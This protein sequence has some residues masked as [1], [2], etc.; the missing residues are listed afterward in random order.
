MDKNKKYNKLFHIWLINLTGLVCLIIIVGGLTRLTDSGLSITAWELFSGILPPMSQESWIKYYD[1]YKKIPQYFLLNNSMTLEEFKVIFLWEYAHRLLARVIGLFFLI[2]F[3]FFI[4]TNFLKKEI[5]LKLTYVFILILIQGLMGW[6]MVQS[7]LIENITVSHYRLSIHLFIAF[8]IL[9]SLIWILL[10]SINKTNKFFFQLNTSHFILKFLLFLLFVQ[11]ILGAFVS[12]LDAGKIYQTWPLMNGNFF[13]DDIPINYFFNFNEP[14][15]VQF[16]HRNVAYFIFFVS[17]YLGINI[18]K[19][20]NR[21]LFRNYLF[22][23]LIILTQIV[24]GVLVLISGVNI[25]FASMHQISSIFL[26]VATINLY[27]RSI[28][29]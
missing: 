12:G 17:V 9:T 20:D 13:P 21:E 8:T 24:L 18:Y 23:F 28:S 27:Y 15:F 25:F 6:Y 1:S 10:N 7:G 29:T 5:I 2:P 19:L 16:L 11:I 4:F 26:V 22:Y 14:S 3:L